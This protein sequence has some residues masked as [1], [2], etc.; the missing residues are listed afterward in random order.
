[1]AGF[2]VRWGTTDTPP[3]PQPTRGFGTRWGAKP[4]EKKEVSID[5]PKPVLPISIPDLT[6]QK[7]KSS[8]YKPIPYMGEGVTGE[9]EV[10]YGQGLKGYFSK[11]LGVALSRKRLLD[12]EPSEE[13]Y[14][15]METIAQ[16]N[17]ET[18]FGKFWDDKLA[19]FTGVT[20]KD[21]FL[22]MSAFDIDQE[23][24]EEEADEEGKTGISKAVSIFGNALQKSVKFGVQTTGTIAWSGVLEPLLNSLDSGVRE[25]IAAPLLAKLDSGGDPI[26][27]KELADI[28]RKSST[29]IYT[30]WTDSVVK[31]NLVQRI[32]SGENPG[33]VA[34]ELDNPLVE[35]AG[36]VFL[37]PSTYFTLGY[38][39][40][41]KLDDV[42]KIRK[43]IIKFCEI[44]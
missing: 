2:G 1:M 10:F 33:L 20:S 5:I 16:A 25:Y 27:Q 21:V 35:L 30:L 6:D 9:G 28:Y 44:N 31:E 38:T 42:A 29:A 23:R 24:T 12:S 36:S 7:L 17:S 19:K 34:L 32:K 37:D 43:L 11:L 40:A 15:K 3:T 4:D 13:E 39:K 22:G 18:D 41:S 26:M 14:K 8:S